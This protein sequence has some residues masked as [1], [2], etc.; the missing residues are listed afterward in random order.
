MANPSDDLGGDAYDCFGGI[1]PEGQN[2]GISGAYKGDKSGLVQVLTETLTTNVVYE[3][4]VEVGRNPMYSWIGYKVQLLAGGIVLAED[5]NSLTIAE[6]TFE[7]SIVTYDSTGADMRLLGKYLEIRL[8]GLS[9]GKYLEIIFDDV[10]LTATAATGPRNPS[11][12]NG[13]YI[14][15]VSELELSWT[16]AAPF[17]PN[18]PEVVYDPDGPVWVDVW[19][20]TD[21]NDYNDFNKIVDA[22]TPAG[23]DA[24]SVMVDLNDLGI[25]YWRVDSYIYGGV[26][27]DPI[28]GSMW[29]F[30]AA[31]DVPVLVEASD[32]ITWS[33]QATQL[34]PNIDDDG[35]SDV[36]YEWSADPATGVVASIVFDPNDIEEP[37]VTITKDFSIIS[38]AN[39]SFEDIVRADGVEGDLTSWTAPDVGARIFNPGIT[40]YVGYGGEAPDGENVLWVNGVGAASQVL[41]DT[42]TADSTYTLTVYVGCNGYYPGSPYKVELVAGETVLAADDN[43]IK[44]KVDVFE[45]SEIEFDSADVDPALLGEPLQIRLWCTKHIDY[46]AESNFDDVHLTVIPDRPFS[47]AVSTVKLTVRAKDGAG[48]DKDTM[49]I[50]VYDT[51]CSAAIINFGQETIGPGDFDADCDTDFKDFATM[52]KE[53]LVNNELTESV[54]KP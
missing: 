22:N 27:G 50:D 14:E 7:T 16:N 35:E 15:P 28:K 29:R 31:N 13:A 33:G 12:A 46:G 43:S 38:I 45:L 9:I 44:L 30:H 18:D 53:W 26:T 40:G 37:T 11:P 25:Y 47:D 36:T 10:R 19:F 52:A 23:E 39:H 8:V 21:P 2:V 51:A 32:M 1:V 34:D 42:L 17:D 20:G 24:N 6:D 54:S 48:S 41:A 4:T 3:L 5:D 49:K